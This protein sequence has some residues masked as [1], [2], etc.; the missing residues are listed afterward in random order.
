MWKKRGADGSPNHKPQKK[1]TRDAHRGAV[2]KKLGK[3]WGLLRETTTGRLWEP[4]LG[5]D[6][7][8]SHTIR[9]GEKKNCEGALE[10]NGV[11]LKKKKKP[12]KGEL[13]RGDPKLAGKTKK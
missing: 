3:T 5:K 11:V 13:R 4:V 6:D 7:K 2:S 1:G 8:T 10:K 9:R 12:K